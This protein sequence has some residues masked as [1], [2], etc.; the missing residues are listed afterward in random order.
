MDENQPFRIIIENANLNIERGYAL[1]TNSI[2]KVKRR[3][4]NRNHLAQTVKISQIDIDKEKKSKELLQKLQEKKNRYS[5]EANQLIS[6]IQIKSKE[7]KKKLIKE[8][9]SA[10]ERLRNATENVQLTKMMMNSEIEIP[11]IESAAYAEKLQEQLQRAKEKIEKMNK[12]KSGWDATLAEL[13]ELEKNNKG[14]L[15][16]RT[17]PKSDFQKILNS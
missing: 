5:E 12:K 9:Y 4:G 13:E 10:T 7:E 17:R 1:L 16:H 3:E 6:S 14:Q 2:L 15:P 11:N 8:I